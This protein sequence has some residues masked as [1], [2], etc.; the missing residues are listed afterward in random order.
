MISPKKNHKNSRKKMKKSNMSVDRSSALQSKEGSKKH[1]LRS[2]MQ[3]NFIKKESQRGE[4][5]R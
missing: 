4:E 2:S 3:G 5:S 1:S